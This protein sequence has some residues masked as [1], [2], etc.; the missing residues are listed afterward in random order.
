VRLAGLVEQLQALARGEAGPPGAAEDV[1]ISELVDSSLAAARTRHPDTTA[2]L[3]APDPGP[4]VHGDAEG[5]R[6]LV[7]NL[8]ENAARHGREGGTIAV[9]VAVGPNGG[10]TVTIDDDGPG[11]PAAERATVLRR[12]TRGSGARGNGTGLG[13]AIALAQAQRHGGDL[14]LDDAPGGGLRAVATVRGT[15]EG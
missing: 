10:A 15:G 1:D 7:D 13:L 8:V 9:R 12:F 4:I 2:N 3:D 14:R 11:I 6:M 5:L